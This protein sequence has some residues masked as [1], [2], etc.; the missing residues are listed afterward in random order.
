M[1]YSVFNEHK[2]EMGLLL[3]P[4]NEVFGQS[5]GENGFVKMGIA[6]EVEVI[7]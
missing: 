6:K 4:E 7:V 3:C 5:G 1:F 2:K